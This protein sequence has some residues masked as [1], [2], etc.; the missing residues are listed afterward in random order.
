MFF[1]DVICHLTEYCMAWF[2]RVDLSGCEVM[3]DL[4]YRHVMLY[5][6]AT[7]SDYVNY[8]LR[9]KETSSNMINTFSIRFVTSDDEVRI[10]TGNIFLQRM[11][12]YL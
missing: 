8:T 4:H 10:I 6:Y 9:Y 3:G 12:R 7:K 11:M 5:I 2:L 1:K